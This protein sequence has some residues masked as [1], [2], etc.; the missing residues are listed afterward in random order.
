LG[1][2]CAEKIQVNLLH[3]LCYEIGAGGDKVNVEFQRI[4]AGLLDHLGIAGPAAGGDPVQATDDRDVNSGF[5]LTDE[6]QVN[7]RSVAVL[8]GLGEIS[9]ASA[10]MKVVSSIKRC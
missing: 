7:I 9:R 4:G 3:I 1:L 10:D 2:D 8:G 5:G 6:L